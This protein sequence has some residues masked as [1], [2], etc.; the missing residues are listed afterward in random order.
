M[1]ALAES[2]I[3]LT[4]ISRTSFAKTKHNLFTAVFGDGS[5]TYPSGGIPIT[6]GK[7]GMVRQLDQLVA[8]KPG[9]DGIAWLYDRVNAKLQGFRATNKTPFLAVAEE[10]KLT[11][12]AG[13]LGFLPSYILAIENV[14]HSTLFG[15]IPSGETPGANECAVNYTTGGI[16]LPA[17]NTYVY[18]TY[19]PKQASGL[20]ASSGLTVAEQQTASGGSITLNDAPIAIQYVY[21]ETDNAQLTIIPDDESPSNGECA[22][23]MATGVITV[24]AADNGDVITVTYLQAADRDATLQ[25][26]ATADISLSSEAIDF[27]KTT[28]YKGL[29]L[30]AYGTFLVGETGGNANAFM[31]IGGPDVTA[32]NNIA[33]WNPELNK[34]LTN[35]SSAINRLNIPLL[36][37][38]HDIRATVAGRELFVTEAIPAQSIVVTAQGW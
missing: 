1:T 36:L 9:T 2:D 5:L 25:L 23:N 34:L 21:N 19:V 18:V 10:V 24:N 8:A 17:T 4:E 6:G 33:K 15:V 14:A 28:G 13:T 29:V 3:T 30:P 35:Q 32:A 31:R 16:T 26:V 11:A 27:H 38:D 37:A 12:N 22:I 7:W 20:F